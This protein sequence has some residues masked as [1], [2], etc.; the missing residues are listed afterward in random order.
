MEQ[1]SWKKTYL[2]KDKGY[3]HE[4]KVQPPRV[5][6]GRKETAVLQRIPS[7]LLALVEDNAMKLKSR[8]WSN[9]SV[10]ILTIEKRRLIAASSYFRARFRHRIRWNPGLNH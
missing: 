9:H 3:L 2:D 7:I 10:E 5:D 4:S 1:R 8:E 6:K